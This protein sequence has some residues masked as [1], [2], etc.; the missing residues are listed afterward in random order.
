MS[1]QKTILIA[2]ANPD[3]SEQVRTD[4]F[5]SVLQEALQ[6][7]EKTHAFDIKVVLATDLDNFLVQ[8]EKIKPQILHLVGHGDRLDN[9]VFESDTGGRE[10]AKPTRFAQALHAYRNTLECVV[11]TACHSQKMATEI[12]QVIPYAIGY[13]ETL[14][15]AVAKAYTY[16]FY[17]YLATGNDY[18]QI[19]QKLRN[20]SPL[21]G[22]PVDKIPKLVSNPLSHSLSGTSL[23]KET[24]SFEDFKIMIES[25]SLTE[26]FEALDELYAQMD[27]STKTTYNQLK[28]EFEGDKFGL[29]ERNIRD[30]LRVAVKKFLA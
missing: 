4:R 29:L 5:V 14:E 18:P 15:V 20:A 30:R 11:I 21:L 24:M 19:D 10:F 2:T 16:W 9:F 6:K 28:R 17:F 1:P 23:S 13:E 22:I 7:A 27:S 12:T 26:V 8:I 3:N 25:K